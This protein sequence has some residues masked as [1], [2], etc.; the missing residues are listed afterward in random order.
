MPLRSNTIRVRVNG[1]KSRPVENAISS[2]NSQVFPSLSPGKD[3]KNCTRPETT[4]PMIIPQP[5][6][7]GPKS[8]LDRNPTT[9]ARSISIKNLRGKSFNKAMKIADRIKMSNR[10]S[11]GSARVVLIRNSTAPIVITRDWNTKRACGLDLF[12]T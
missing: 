7:A 4:K 9:K 6:G 11:P 1:S 8:M 3:L 2:Q 12:M 10:Y 5:A